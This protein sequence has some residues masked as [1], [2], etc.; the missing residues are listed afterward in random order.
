MKF[1]E[2]L[3][4]L[5]PTPYKKWLRNYMVFAGFKVT[6]ACYFGFTLTYAVV[7]A[8]LIFLLFQVGILPGLYFIILAPLTSVGFVVFMH[9]ILIVNADKRAGFVEDVLPDMLRMLA[10]NLRSGL[11]IDRALL[12]SARP[13]FGFFEAQIKRAAHQTMTGKSVEDAL[14]G[15]VT[16]FR[17]KMLR[18]SIDLLKDGLKRGA[19]LPEMLDGLAQE[20]REMKTLRRE[21]VAHVMLY[22]IFIFFAAGIAAPLLYAIASFLIRTLTQVG[23]GVAIPA[24]A[25]AELPVALGVAQIEPAFLEL[26]SLLAM[27][28]TSVFAGL[29]IG[30][31]RE[32]SERGGIKLIPVLLFLSLIVYYLA[33]SMVATIF[34]IPV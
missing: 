29:L 22:V 19:N 3:W 11:T 17:S 21:V 20:I 23:A 10:A 12:A 18:R 4:V 6:P 15:M 30:L 34:A 7:I 5:A 9:A 26:Y 1:Y 33:K 13:E 28:I 16:G 2:R 31:V 32:G 8:A 25:P 27:I 14:D 24:E